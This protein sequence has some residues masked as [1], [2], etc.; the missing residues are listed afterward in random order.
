MKECPQKATL[1]TY[2]LKF[3]WNNKLA[4]RDM[5][6]SLR[7]RELVTVD[8]KK[9]KNNGWESGVDS[10]PIGVDAC[11]KWYG[12]EDVNLHKMKVMDMG[13]YMEMQGEGKSL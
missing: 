8:P 6:K 2:R 3:K 4:A 5:M 10:F 1:T 9:P 7:G 13:I 12:F 11:I